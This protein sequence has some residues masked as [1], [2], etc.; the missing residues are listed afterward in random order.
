MKK[1]TVKEIPSKIKE[2]KKPAVVDKK[3]EEIKEEHLAEEASHTHVPVLHR[4][5]TLEEDALPES[6]NVQSRA[7]REVS[8]P[9]YEGSRRSYTLSSNPAAAPE[10]NVIYEDP[11][12]ASARR[13]GTVEK[14]T[15]L[16]RQE[17]LRTEEDALGTRPTVSQNPLHPRQQL[18]REDTYTVEQ[19]RAKSDKKRRYPWEA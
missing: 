18:R 1:T 2:I 5:R 6:S 19:E 7:P 8:K 3:I 15:A 14:P 10:Q 12:V 16:L 4:T 17:F 11:M 13:T 9:L